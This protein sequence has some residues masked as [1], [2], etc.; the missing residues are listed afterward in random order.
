MFD[1]TKILGALVSDSVDSGGF[2]SQRRHHR[3]SS[4]GLLDDIPGGST[5]KML[6]G[7]AGIAAAGGLAYMAYQHFKQPA[8]PGAPQQ[9][10]PGF[11]DNLLGSPA[12]AQ[13]GLGAPGSGAAYGAAQYGVPAYHNDPS[14]WGSSIPAAPP[15]PAANA[16]NSPPPQPPPQPFA[17][18]SAGFSASPAP[19]GPPASPPPG[20]GASSEYTDALLLVRAMVTAA[21]MDGQID[22]NERARILDRLAK[23]GLPASEQQALS[24]EL[25]APQP[26]YA[27]L[28]QIRSH[29]VATQF[30]AVS[31]LAAGTESEAERAYLKGLPPTLG[32][33]PDEVAQLHQMLG[34]PLI[35]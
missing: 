16:W 9:S 13:P 8:Q 20:P 30:Y 7:A 19:A 15:P 11:F 3:Q 2:H 29:E 24:R 31:L 27:L 35:A 21:N 4:G 22:E 5:G 28:G 18:S 34:I 25:S 32:L 12:P 33:K 6:A 14:T 17:S 1:A 26:P 10:G 23:S